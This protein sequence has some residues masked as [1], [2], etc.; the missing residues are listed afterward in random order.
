[1]IGRARFAGATAANARQQ[2]EKF[3]GRQSVGQRQGS[4]QVVGNSDGPW[5][6][7]TLVASREKMKRLS[8]CDSARLFV[9]ARGEQR[10]AV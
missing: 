10:C 7:G 3:R 1:M 2:T 6:P 4:C 5:R 8:F 9:V